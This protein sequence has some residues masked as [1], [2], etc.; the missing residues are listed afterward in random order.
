[1][2]MFLF[3]AGMTT[4]VAPN[5]MDLS[6]KEGTGMEGLTVCGYSIICH[7]LMIRWQLEGGT[8]LLLFNHPLF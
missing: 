4:A 5:C 8:L 1:M 7:L 3:P 2:F 6:S